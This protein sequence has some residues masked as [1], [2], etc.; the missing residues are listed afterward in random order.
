MC[1]KNPKTVMNVSDADLLLLLLD[2]EPVQRRRSPR[3]GAVEFGDEVDNE[4][5]WTIW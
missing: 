3:D 4:L 5:R 1:K 2:A